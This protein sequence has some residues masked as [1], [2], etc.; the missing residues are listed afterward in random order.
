MNPPSTDSRGAKATPGRETATRIAIL[1]PCVFYLCVE[2]AR[3]SAYLPLV[4]L[5]RLGMWASLWGFATA[6]FSG[7]FRTTKPL[8]LM[9]C[10]LAL[11]ALQVILAVNNKRAFD[12]FY[13]FSLLILGSLAP[14]IVL[15]RSVA[16]VRVLV[17]AYFALHFPT[18][19]H[20]ILHSGTGLNGWL[21]D[22]NDLAFALLAALGVGIYLLFALTRMRDKLLTGGMIALTLLCIV[23]TDSRGGFLGL[24]GQIAY[25]FVMGP[26]RKRIA[27]VLIV[28]ALLAIPFVPASY[29]SDMQT[30]ETSTNH[31]DTGYQRLV[32]WAIAWEMFKA[33]P[34]LGVGSGNFPVQ[35]QVYSP[36]VKTYMFVPRNFWG[37]AAHSLYF[38]LL[39]E[40]GVV[41]TIIFVALIVWHFRASRRIRRR[42]LM[43]AST[44]DQ[45]WVTCLASGLDAAMVGALTSGTF[46]SVIYYPVIW[47]LIALM[48]ALDQVVPAVDNGTVRQGTAEAPPT[49]K[50]RGALVPS[51]SASRA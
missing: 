35:T 28:A 16:E 51:R 7:N 32:S 10:F 38:T 49:N 34:I 37:R 24:V 50:R 2:F 1:A 29:W 15:P 20:G 21:E 4:D 22:E 36:I 17:I 47:V 25:L 33:N 18:V 11:M 6:I 13:S 26:H 23:L 42:A 30:I 8:R 46:I 39:S 43:L 48:A 3:P 12:M 19:I 40:Q 44:D 41:G 27:I 31:D 45:R 9:L 5:L 14:L